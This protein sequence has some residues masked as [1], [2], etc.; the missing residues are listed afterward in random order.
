MAATP[1]W[2][3][4]TCGRPEE[5]Q[6]P[7]ISP[8]SVIADRRAD[9]YVSMQRG[10]D[11]RSWH[12]HATVGHV[13]SRQHKIARSSGRSVVKE[14]R[15]RLR[16]ASAPAGARPRPA[17]AGR[18]GTSKSGTV[19]QARRGRP[20]SAS[21]MLRA[22]D[23]WGRPMR[24]THGDMFLSDIEANE[25][26]R[27]IDTYK[28]EKHVCRDKVDGVD[29]LADTSL[30]DLKVLH[31]ASQRQRSKGAT[32]R[33]PQSAGSICSG[34]RHQAPDH[35]RGLCQDLVSDLRANM[36]RLD[37]SEVESLESVGAGVLREYLAEKEE[38]KK[39]R[40]RVELLAGFKDFFKKKPEP[41]EESVEQTMLPE[42]IPATETDEPDC[43]AA[44]KSRNNASDRLGELVGFLIGCCGSVRNAFI[45]FDMNQ[46]HL[47]SIPEWEDGIKKLGFLDDVSYVFRLLG[48]GNDDKVTLNEIQELFVPFLKNVP[49][50]S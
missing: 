9:K 35:M 41:E 1:K 32:T 16:P 40:E 17:S 33:R 39:E 2:Q 19:E 34:S 38:V 22:L 26:Q 50:D 3:T 46:D 31:N 48:K 13:P 37:D 4:T 21:S 7:P 8:L 36:K 49:Q 45:S 30:Y 27:N 11:T 47:L 5:E 20:Q 10:C 14:A 24:T 29:A 18:P 25:V 15:P 44:G 28:R 23:E 43:R 42:P 6:G 12:D